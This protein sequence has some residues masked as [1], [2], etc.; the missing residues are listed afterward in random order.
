MSSSKIL[1]AASILSADFAKLGEEVTKLV[2]AEV[3]L[4]HF[5]VMDNHFVPNL[6]MGAQ[7][8]AAIKPYAQGVGIDVHLMTYN[9][10]ELVKEFAKSGATSIT[11][12]S[13]A[14]IHQ[15]R[16]INFA[17][18]LGLKVGVALNPS[19]SL[20]HLEYLLEKIDIVLVMAVNPG[21]GGQ[22]F[23]PYTLDKIATLRKM[24]NVRNREIL[25]AVDGGIN[26]DNIIEV[27]RAGANMIIA[28]NSILK[29]NNYQQT[30][31]KF[32]NELTKLG[33]FIV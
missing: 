33:H 8:C 26:E 10:E 19:T 14:V 29:S 20:V 6:T 5:D 12:H 27:V 28:G 21:F 7:I 18:E 9:V 32:R 15:D 22:K 2:E 3:D 1:I 23:I 4:I 11:F 13:E 16:V 31:T 17:K 25:L 30:V 24:I